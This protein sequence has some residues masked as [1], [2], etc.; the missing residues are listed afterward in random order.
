MFIDHMVLSHIL[1][2]ISPVI[3]LI[4]P[5]IKV[6]L[7]KLGDSVSIDQIEE[8]LMLFDEAIKLWT[9]CLAAVLLP[10]GSLT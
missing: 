8:E 6:S 2:S 4:K 1:C 3:T 7:L 5:V 9:F 10:S